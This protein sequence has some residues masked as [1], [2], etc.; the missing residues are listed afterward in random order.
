M[1]SPSGSANGGVIGT[2][3]KSSFGK[4]TVTTVT[5]TGNS[6][7]R[8]GT[9][10]VDATVVAG[11]GGGGVNGNS[12]GGG[13]AGGFRNFTNIVVP[14]NVPVTI[15]GGGAGFPAPGCQTSNGTPGDDTKITVGSTEYTSTGGG[16]G[17]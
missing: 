16:G 8:S 10:L 2:S 6:S 9:R 17:G 14:G 5:A 12:G 1:A 7:F 13:G 3:N 4:N 15:G 11:G